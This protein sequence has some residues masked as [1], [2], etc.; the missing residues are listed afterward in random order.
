MMTAP[1][2]SSTI[3][4]C[5]ASCATQGMARSVATG[6]RRCVVSTVDDATMTAEQRELHRAAATGLRG[7]EEACA[8]HLP[9]RLAA[10]ADRRVRELLD[11]E[12]RPHELAAWP[13]SP[14][15]TPLE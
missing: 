12:C 5:S 2:S 10:L 9:G 8:T 14:Q 7:V 6:W 13:T 11:P 1:P 3:R 15:F 4:A